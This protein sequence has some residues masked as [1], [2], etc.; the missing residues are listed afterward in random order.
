MTSSTSVRN[1]PLEVSTPSPTHPETSHDGGAFITISI[2]VGSS[3][4]SG[5]EQ[6]VP[7]STAARVAQ[8]RRN[9]RPR[10]VRRLRP[11]GTGSCEPD[12]RVDLQNRPLS[13]API[14]ARPCHTDVRR[15]SRSASHAPSRSRRVWHRTLI[16]DRVRGRGRGRRPRRPIRRSN[17]APTPVPVA[18]A[19][20]RTHAT[21]AIAPVTTAGSRRRPS[22]RPRWRR[23]RS[24][25]RTRSHRQQPG[26]ADPDGRPR[27][28]RRRAR[29]RPKSRR[30]TPR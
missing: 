9:Q 16:G 18:P 30:A 21:K 3:S 11:T 24:P 7:M 12:A 28:A 14:L 20:R 4:V 26:R 25:A 13:T 15:V 23:A 17:Q 10:P 6:A 8:D 1:A 22:P 19:A 27:P 2:A 5:D 29:R